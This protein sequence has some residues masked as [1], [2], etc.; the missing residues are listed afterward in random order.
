[1]LERRLSRRCGWGLFP[2]F[3]S[4]IYIHI[5]SLVVTT[6]TWLTATWVVAWAAVFATVFCSTIVILFVFR[7]TLVFSIVCLWGWCHL[8]SFWLLAFFSVIV[9]RWLWFLVARLVLS[10][11]WSESF[12][13]LCLA[14]SRFISAFFPI[15]TIVLFILFFCRTLFV[16]WLWWFPLSRF[17]LVFFPRRSLT[18]LLRALSFPISVFLSVRVLLATLA[19][20]FLAFM[21]FGRCIFNRLICGIGYLWHFFIR[22][23][24]LLWPPSLRWWS[25][26]FIPIV[27]IVPAALDE[28]VTW[29]AEIPIIIPRVMIGR[30]MVSIA[31]VTRVLLVVSSW[32]TIITAVSI[33]VIVVATFD[34]V[35]ITIIR[36]VVVSFPI[37]VA[38]RVIVIVPST[39]RFWSIIW[40]SRPRL[41]SS[42]TPTWVSP[43]SAIRS[44]LTTSL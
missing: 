38:S 19:M 33:S 26:R 12:L 13:L 35:S 43:V 10:F 28:N 32:V 7:A 22:Y 29:S 42:A 25:I 37:S 36:V 8:L 24:I 30:S 21:P 39:P 27:P 1:M 17:T 2:L 34:A 18:R 23:W 41:V 40:W 14:L 9:L 11:C 6:F 5:F 4:F 3:S 20:F 15:V 31:P 16:F 44:L